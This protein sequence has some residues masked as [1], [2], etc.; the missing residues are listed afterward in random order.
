MFETHDH[1]FFQPS[2]VRLIKIF[3]STTT[4]V[5]GRA[6]VLFISI[7]RIKSDKIKF[8]TT[9]ERKFRT[10]L[11]ENSF[12]DYPNDEIFTNDV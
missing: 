7:T 6:Y 10:D 4:K 5:L 12:R 8:F 11:S 1:D 3:S 9:S 2:L